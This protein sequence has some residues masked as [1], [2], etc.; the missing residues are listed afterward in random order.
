MSVAYYSEIDGMVK[1]EPITPASSD[2]ATAMINL[3]KSLGFINLF[4]ARCEFA[5]GARA[6]YCRAVRANPCFLRAVNRPELHVL[7]RFFPNPQAFIFAFA[8]AVS[9]RD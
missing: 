6:A 2:T 5:V 7:A 9:G 8:P 4:G 3:K 1:T